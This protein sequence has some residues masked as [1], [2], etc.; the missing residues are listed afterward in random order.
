VWRIA[1][2][3]NYAINPTP[4]QALRSN[5][6]V[7]P[8]R[9][10]AALALIGD[11]MS[12][13]AL[14]IGC[15]ISNSI[16]ACTYDEADQLAKL[17]DLKNSVAAGSLNEEARE[18][19]WTGIFGEKYA[20]VYGGCDH[21]GHRITV[22]GADGV[23]STKTEL[24]TIWQKLADAYWWSGEN[25]ILR[26]ALETQQFTSIRSVTGVRYDLIGTDY[27]EMYLEYQQVGEGLVITVGWV[28]TF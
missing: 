28:R 7:L 12:I 4:E 24:F 1:L 26:Q 17:T 9:V 2:I 18:V 23:L 3:P 25:A 19:T 27:D 16:A 6:A 21:L 5:Q 8:A 20:L 10:I 14:I 13:R 15:L 11:S 22:T